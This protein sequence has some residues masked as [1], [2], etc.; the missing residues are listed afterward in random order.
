VRA[1]ILA[2]APEMKLV[3]QARPRRVRGHHHTPIITVFP[4]VFLFIIHMWL[5]H[6]RPFLD[7]T[8]ELAQGMLTRHRPVIELRQRDYAYQPAGGRVIDEFTSPTLDMP[9]LG[10]IAQLVD[11]WNGYDRRQT[12]H[13]KLPSAVISCPPE[14]GC[15]WRFA[16]A[17]GHIGLR[18]V[19]PVVLT[20][21]SVFYPGT[22]VLP[23]IRQG[24]IPR[25]IRVWGLADSSWTTSSLFEVR[26]LHKFYRPSA[27]LESMDSTDWL[28]TDVFVLLASFDHPMRNVS[29]YHYQAF[30]AIDLVT[31]HVVVEVV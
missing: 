11:R 9:E 26:P 29:D 28:A 24:E 17:Y 21:I 2:A 16:G 18:L 20:G 7:D 13:T 23:G 14:L 10:V 31:S 1:E 22:N 15:C 6:G 5:T 3:R 30:S 25:S 12:S 4:M 19:Q 27:K 8:V